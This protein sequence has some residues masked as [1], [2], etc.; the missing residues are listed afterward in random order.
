MS[1][2]DNDEPK[3]QH[4]NYQTSTPPTE[5]RKFSNLF[6]IMILLDNVFHIPSCGLTS[7]IK[8]FLTYAQNAHSALVVTG[9]FSS[10]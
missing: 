4:A 3:G 10:S 5:H 2:C 6:L 8:E 7:L 9:V 1:E